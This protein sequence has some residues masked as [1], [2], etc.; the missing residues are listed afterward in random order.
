LLYGGGFAIARLVAALTTPHAI[1]A[2][3]LRVS[4]IAVSV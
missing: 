3:R 4:R 2:I 1:T